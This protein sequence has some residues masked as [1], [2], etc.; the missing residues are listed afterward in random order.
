M[1]FLLK[2]L[3]ILKRAKF[4]SPPKSE[5]AVFDFRDDILEKLVLQDIQFSV[6][7]ADFGLLYIS[8]PVVFSFAK[9]FLRIYFKLKEHRRLQLIYSL[10]C[11][12]NI[13]PKVVIT[14]IDNN[15]L[16]HAISQFYAE[17]EFYAIQNGERYS[18]NLKDT[19]QGILRLGIASSAC[20][21][22]CFGSYEIEAYRKIGHSIYNKF[23]PVGSVIGGYYWSQVRPPNLKIEFTIC[24]VSQWRR[25]IMLGNQWPTHK[26][27]C[28]VLDNYLLSF[29]N[30]KKI[31]LC[32]AASRPDEEELKYYKNTFGDRAQII[33]N[34]REQLSTYFAMGK[35]DIILTHSSTAGYEAFGWGKKVLFCNFSGD[36][37]FDP[38]VGGLNSI[39]NESY[40]EF[41]SKLD[42]LIEIDNAEYSRL[43]LNP[44]KYVMNYDFNMPAHN[45][46][47][48]IIKELQ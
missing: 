28:E 48:K 1:K 15:Y 12:Q 45:Y 11:I 19:L 31:S 24:L 16:F 39:S 22:I 17:A 18:C 46:M 32:I 34:N 4:R 26:K 8:F 14:I 10:S 21:F 40:E 33:P 47:R 25:Q 42:H 41:R 23:H 9:N 5:V 7:P 35:S 44:R 29:I 20:N 13:K 43:T 2:L 27:A 30:E 37:E 38:L 6:I 36:S 3:R